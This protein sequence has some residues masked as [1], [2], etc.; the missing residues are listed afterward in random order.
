MLKDTAGPFSPLLPY[1]QWHHYL[2]ITV[3]TNQAL[4]TSYTKSNL[5]WLIIMKVQ[6]QD[7]L[8]P[9]SSE[10]DSGEGSPQWQENTHCE[11]GSKQG[12]RIS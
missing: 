5:F 9:L 4:A 12:P 1:T 7:W 11:P 2:G 6:E 10:R 3:A 8:A